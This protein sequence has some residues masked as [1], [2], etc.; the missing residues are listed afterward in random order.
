MTTAAEPTMKNEP[1]VLV[2]RVTGPNAEG[3]S[4]AHSINITYDVVGIGED[5]YIAGAVACVMLPA[6]S[7]DG[8][9]ADHHDQAVI[10]AAVDAWTAEE[11]DRQRESAATAA[12]KL[13]AEDWQAEVPLVDSVKMWANCGEA[14]VTEDGEVRIAVPQTDHWLG[15]DELVALVAWLEAI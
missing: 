12:I 9:L 4:G 11:L 14:E 7:A 3:H 10:D 13:M 6:F 15:R 2:T 5:R 1:E 8:E